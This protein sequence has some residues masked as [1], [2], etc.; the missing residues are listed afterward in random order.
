MNQLTI[1]LFSQC[2]DFICSEKH[3]QM[4]TDICQHLVFQKLET[5]DTIRTTSHRKIQ[6]LNRSWA[7]DHAPILKYFPIHQMKT[8]AHMYIKMEEEALPM[9]EPPPPTIS[10]R[11]GELLP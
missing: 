6:P 4:T 2:S 10:K 8:I 9:L 5:S 3:F 7:N 1:S 11:E